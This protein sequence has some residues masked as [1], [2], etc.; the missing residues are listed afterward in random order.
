MESR[1]YMNNELAEAYYLVAT[2]DRFRKDT[3]KAVK[4]RIENSERDIE[5][6]FF[7]NGNLNGL[8]ITGI[9]KKTKEI[10]EEILSGVDV[11]E[12][13]ETRAKDFRK[14]SEDK[15]RENMW[16]GIPDRVEMNEGRVVDSWIEG[17]RVLY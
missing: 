7:K 17:E 13:A 4:L 6:Y 16:E 15:I 10:L 11:Y 1:H 8:K 3:Y 5:N 9:A 12:L 2:S 14:K